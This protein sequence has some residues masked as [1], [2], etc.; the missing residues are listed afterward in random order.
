MGISRPTLPL[1]PKSK[2][3]I[4]S[5]S[6]EEVPKLRLKSGF[7]NENQCNIIYACELGPNI[8]DYDNM[9]TKIPENNDKIT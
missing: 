5:L 3:G 7:R 8:D 4:L 9:T 1:P 2:L 6:P